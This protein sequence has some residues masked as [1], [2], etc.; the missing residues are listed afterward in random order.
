MDISVIVVTYNQQDTV[1]R[2]LD[3]ILSQRFSGDFEIIIGDDCSADSTQV[4]CESYAERYP[5]KIRYFRRPEN[6][7]LVANYYDC[8]RRAAGRYIADC[9]GDD[10]WVDDT[11]LQRQ[12]DEMQA[13]P[14]VTMVTTDWMCCNTD[15][16]NIRP[17]P[18]RMPIATRQ[19][20]A[21]GELVVPI[22]ANSVM[23][24][25]CSALYRRDLV[26]KAMKE[27]PELMCGS[28]CSCEDL[29]IMALMADVGKIVMLPQITTYYTVGHDS[30]SHSANITRAFNHACK[31]VLQH[32]VLADYFGVAHLLEDYFKNKIDY[33][34]AL[35]FHSGESECLVGLS[36]AKNKTENRGGIKSRLYKIAMANKTIWKI[37]R[38]IHLGKRRAI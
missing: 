23:L 17:Y 16:T 24:H 14:A 28:N 29:Q 18:G 2:T 36:M 37:I 5:E 1:G 33:L 8:I 32:L 7:G 15:G 3:S 6:M 11:K 21:P 38:R 34:S 22:L 10:F 9:A 4:I 30:V 20:F 26:I 25:L 31:V 12:F 13:D 35:A 27:I 19:E